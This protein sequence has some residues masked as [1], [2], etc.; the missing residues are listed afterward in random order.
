MTEGQYGGTVS[1]VEAPKKSNTSTIILI[2]VLVLL[3]CCCVLAVVSYFWLGD[4]VLEW[5]NT[6]QIQSGSIRSLMIL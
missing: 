5:W 1:P 3:L 6:F 2:V 4:I